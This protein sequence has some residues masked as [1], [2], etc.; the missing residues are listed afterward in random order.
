MGR[1][2]GA[3]SRQIRLREI[4]GQIFRKCSAEFVSRVDSQCNFL[5]TQKANA[6]FCWGRY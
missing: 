5:F 6:R 3:I 2:R 4:D 1:D